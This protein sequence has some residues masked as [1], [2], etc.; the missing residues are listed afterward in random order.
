M[1][2]LRSSQLSEKKVPIRE[3]V[4]MSMPF[5]MQTHFAFHRT[6]SR[7]RKT[8]LDDDWPESEIFTACKGGKW[9][10]G[11]CVQGGMYRRVVAS[12]SLS[13]SLSRL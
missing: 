12:L 6:L 13:F 11:G 7:I 4:K 3:D 5:C 1:S 9:V 10:C 2:R 8:K